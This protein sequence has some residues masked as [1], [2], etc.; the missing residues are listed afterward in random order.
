MSWYELYPA[1]SGPPSVAWMPESKA[2]PRS[3]IPM[4]MKFQNCPIRPAL[5]P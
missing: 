2:Q 3:F 4:P 5:A 1:Y